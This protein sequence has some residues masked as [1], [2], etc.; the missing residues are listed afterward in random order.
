RQMVNGQM[1]F[2]A[3]P[4][5]KRMLTRA[6]ERFEKRQAAGLDP[7]APPMP[8]DA[9]KLTEGLD[10]DQLRALRQGTP[11]QRIDAFAALPRD[12]QDEAI[13]AMPPG[14]RQ[15]IFALAPP[16]LP[17]RIEMPNAPH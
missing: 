4:D 16:E 12:Q 1:P 10:A 2:P 8:G 13:E 9:R 6:M 11:Q 3:D 14:M 5:R 17:P 7:N 15:N